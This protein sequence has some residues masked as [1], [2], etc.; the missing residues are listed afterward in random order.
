VNALYLTC[1]STPE[2]VR[3]NYF[4]ASDYL[5]ATPEASEIVRRPLATSQGGSYHE[6]GPL[7]PSVTDPGY[8]ALLQWARGARPPQPQNLDPA[9]RLSRRRSSPSSSRRAA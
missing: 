8:R 9:S 3:W 7:F 2:E 1:G 5:A 4:A 6:G